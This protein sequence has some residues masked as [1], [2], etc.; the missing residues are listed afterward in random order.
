VA[1]SL[2]VLPES[3]PAE[4]TQ[5]T[6]YDKLDSPRV[7]QLRTLE[8]WLA[9][10]VLLALGVRYL[11]PRGA[12][13]GLFLAV[14]SAP[15]WIS[16]LKQYHWARFYVA[17]GGLTVVWGLILTATAAT[18]HRVS[19]HNAYGTTFLLLE[20]VTGVG[21]IVWART[22]LP[23]WQVGTIYAAGLLIHAKLYPGSLG[24]TNP[25]KFNW[26]LPLAVLAFSLAFQANRWIQAA[27]AAILGVAAA[28]VD[29][30]AVF[31]TALITLVVLAWQLRPTTMNHRVQWGWTAATLVALGFAVYNL[32]TTLLIN[33]YLGSEAQ[34]RSVAQVERSGSLLLGGRPELSAS[35]ALI[36]HFPGGFGPGV[37]A[38]F[39]EVNVAKAGMM[40][41]SYDPNNGYVNRYMFGTSVELHSTFGDL[42][43]GF[44]IPGLFLALLVLVLVIGGVSRLVAARGATALVVFLSGWTL[45]NILFSP[46]LSAAPTLFLAVGLAL[47][48]RDPYRASTAP[49]AGIRHQPERSRSG[50]L[51]WATR[52]SGVISNKS[53][54]MWKA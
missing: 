35:W 30:R 33:G 27:M 17:F 29:A 24:A 36:T 4:G 5:P 38:N 41:I 15:M 3:A 28:A 54:S 1:R 45:W 14:F 39:G 2:V 32:A 31:G 44:G 43:A 53:T 34:E 40:S 42:W 7:E 49:E 18:D 48:P 37:I 47:R 21:V 11:L 6:A 46:L 22:L 25:L 51:M 23:T 19:P 16:R 50:R 52:P 20:I 10:V 12:G 13:S 8:R 26:I 9:A